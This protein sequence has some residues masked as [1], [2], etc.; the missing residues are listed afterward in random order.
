MSIGQANFPRADRS[1]P[2][3]CPSVETA[4]YP[5][6]LVPLSVSGTSDAVFPSQHGNFRFASPNLDARLCTHYLGQRYHRWQG[7]CFQTF[8][9]LVSH[10]CQKIEPGYVYLSDPAWALENSDGSREVGKGM[11]IC[12]KISLQGEM[13]LLWDNRRSWEP[14]ERGSRSCDPPRTSF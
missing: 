9:H 12:C 13:G 3:S 4:G 11:F 8:Q 6:F 10:Q 7:D 1:F 14:P 5:C 2:S